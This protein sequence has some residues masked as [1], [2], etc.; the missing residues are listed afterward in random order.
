M[1]HHDKNSG[2]IL[3]LWLMLLIAFY[4]SAGYLASSGL[5]ADKIASE[6][7]HME[8]IDP[9]KTE[10]GKTAPDY[11]YLNGEQYKS[12]K[13]E[14]GMYVDRIETISTKETL[15]TVDFYLW[16][17]W[18]GD[19]INPGESFH[20]V[21]GEVLS[22]PLVRSSSEGDN[23]YALYKV[24]ARI[25]KMFDITRY[26]LDNHQ[27]TIRVEESDHQWKVLQYVPDFKE[28]TY[29]S[30][31]NVPGYMIH[32]SDLV[33]KPH[34]YKSSRGDPLAPQAEK[35]V[36]TQL[37]Y[38]LGI[39]RP[40]WGLYFKMFQGLFASV[41]IAFLAFLLVPAADDRISL[42]VGAFFAAM[43]NAY[44]NLAELP[45][46]GR[47]TLTDMVNGIGMVTILLTIFA[48]IISTHIAESKGDVK[49]ARAFDRI[50]LVLFIVGFVGVNVAI[51]VAAT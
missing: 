2:S 33:N 44:I 50:S 39:E 34:A 6:V 5:Y 18:V 27:L 26:P 35:A 38:A 32:S 47:V 42:G 4:V 23:H 51:V 13:V 46:V 22:K 7:R 28:T 40:D 17:K 36:Y 49:H 1:E 16:F 43:A 25:T 31:V 19:E 45:G 20:V 41:A 10:K 21:D 24:A 9:D 15:W 12:Q 8:R 3:M 37:T 29:S 30:R 48:T 11:R 14:V